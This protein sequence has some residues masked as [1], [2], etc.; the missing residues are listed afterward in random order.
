[1]WV[2]PKYPLV[3]FEYRAHTYA[4]LLNPLNMVPEVFAQISFG[5]LLLANPSI[6]CQKKPV[7]PSTI[8][9]P[10]QPS[11][12]IINHHVPLGFS[13][14]FSTFFPVPQ[15]NPFR[16]PWPPWP[17]PK[18]AT[19]HRHRGGAPQAADVLAH[20]ITAWQLGILHEAGYLGRS[21]MGKNPGK[22]PEKPWGK[23][24]KMGKMGKTLEKK[25]DSD[26]KEF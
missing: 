23:M 4:I 21:N 16:T 6:C 18:P 12:T 9:N 8:I 22:Q 24:G 14:G 7:H 15:G 3:L 2:K 13:M 25:H 20:H 11:S 1:M 19:D 10:H 26:L 17:R 5:S